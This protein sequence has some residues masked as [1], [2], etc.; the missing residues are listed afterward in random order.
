MEEYMAE[1]KTGYFH[2]VTALSPTRLWINNVTPAEARL[3]L[4]AG[5]L[6][7]TQNP[8]YPYKMLTHP[9]DSARCYAAL[10]AILKAEKDDNRA[11]CLLQYALVKEIAEEFLPLHK[12]S[13]GR[14]GYVTIQADPFHEQ[15]ETILEWARLHTGEYPN[16][17]AKIPAI[18]AGFAVMEILLAEGRPILATEVMSV[19][20]MLDCAKLYERFLQKN[21]KAPVM[22]F[23]HIPGIFD[24]YITSAVKRDNIDVPADYVWQ[25]GVAVAKKIGALLVENRYGIGFCSGGARGLHHFTELV[26]APCSIT[27]NWG[28]S[29]DKLIEQD[30]PVVQR[31]YCPVPPAVTDTLRELV[32][33]FRK[34]YETKGLTPEEYESFGPVALFRSNFETGWRK[35]NEFIAKRRQE[36]GL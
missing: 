22:Y 20:Q 30:Q 7:C 4:T 9:E 18:P 25:G 28:G 29:A 6:G 17:M 10:D 32:P 24:E 12:A 36:L 11:Q 21:E 1:E 35:A 26:G 19:A 31:F 33:D 13:F 2:R 34:A 27:I 3:A 14:T 16:I 5:A 15:F 23:A 8:A